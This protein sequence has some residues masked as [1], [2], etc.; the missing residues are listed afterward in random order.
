MIGYR[1]EKSYYLTIMD[2]GDTPKL[3]ASSTNFLPNT[4]PEST[5]PCQRGRVYI[6]KSKP[7]PP[8]SN[9]SFRS[10]H[11]LLRLLFGIFFRENGVT[12]EKVGWAL[13]DS[14]RADFASLVRWA[15]I[16]VSHFTDT[17]DSLR[18]SLRCRW[19]WAL[20]DSNN[21]KRVASLRVSLVRPGRT[22]EFLLTS[23]AETRWALPDSN[24]ADF[25]PLVRW[26]RLAH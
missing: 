9:P 16:R 6:S 25:A 8:S 14:N 26:A 23:F 17:D 3:K 19:K 13:P 1:T 11:S 18:S 21:A 15:R 20:P 5:C 24:R 10:F 22:D 7:G 2:G 12:E 4:I